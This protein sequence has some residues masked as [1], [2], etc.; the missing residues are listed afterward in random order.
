MNLTSGAAFTGVQLAETGFDVRSRRRNRPRAG[1]AKNRSQPIRLL[2][3]QLRA[4]DDGLAQL[5]NLRSARVLHTPTG[6][7]GHFA[8]VTG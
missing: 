5:P 8:P 7:L 4:A 1:P 3:V 6:S 2:P